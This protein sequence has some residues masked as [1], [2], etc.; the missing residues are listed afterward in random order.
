MPTLVVVG[1]IIPVQ[2]NGVVILLDI[3]IH[4]TRWLLNIRSTFQISNISQKWTVYPPRETITYPTKKGNTQKI[5]RLK[6]STVLGWDMKNHS[7]G[8]VISTRNGTASSTNVKAFHS[9]Q[10]CRT[11]KQKKTWQMGPGFFRQVKL[12]LLYK[13]LRL[14]LRVETFLKG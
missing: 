5:I 13:N 2:H 8:R 11:S 1:K 14:K 9:L 12:S 3:F 7:L 10:R 4:R 6:K